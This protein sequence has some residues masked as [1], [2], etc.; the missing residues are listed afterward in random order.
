MR[1]TALA[2]QAFANDDLESRCTRETG[3][4]VPGEPYLFATDDDGYEFEIWYEL[5][6]PMDPVDHDSVGVPATTSGVNGEGD[7]H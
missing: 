5:P 2:R 7:G 1:R 6:T 3:E 4:F